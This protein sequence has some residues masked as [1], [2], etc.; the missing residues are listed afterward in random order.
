MNRSHTHDHTSSTNEPIIQVR[1]NYELFDRLLVIAVLRTIW[2]SQI[3]KAQRQHLWVYQ[4]IEMK[5][6]IQ[7]QSNSGILGALSAN[8]NNQTNL[9]LDEAS[10]ELSNNCNK[11]QD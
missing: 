10:E 3:Q 8:Q 2:Q 4:Y 6:C 5:R 1:I 7:H 9:L 11:S